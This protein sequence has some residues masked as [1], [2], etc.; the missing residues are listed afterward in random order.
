MESVRRRGLFSEYERAL[1]QPHKDTLLHAIA[2]TWL[3]IEVAHA[4][5]AACDSLGLTPDQQVQVGRGTFD[6]ARG[7]LLGTAVRMARGAGVTPW[8]AFPLF[9][10]FWERGCDGGGILIRR[11]GPKDAHI[12]VV[13]CSLIVSSHY[14]H[15]LRGLCTALVELFCT[16]AYVTERR[17]APANVWA[18][19][20]QWA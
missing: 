9:Q 20:V 10:R 19:R 7:T 6:G 5:Y 8:Q 13:Q 4:H 11:V 15:G 14:R 16:K 12:D 2:G 1:L 3:P 18:V 17:G